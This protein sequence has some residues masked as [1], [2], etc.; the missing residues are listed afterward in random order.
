MDKSEMTSEEQLALWV[1]GNSQ[2][3]GEKRG[4]GQCCP[5]S[6][7]CHPELLAPQEVREIFAGAWKNQN[8]QMTDRMLME[9]LGKAFAQQ[10]ERVYIAGLEA[11]R[12]EID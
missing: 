10:G 3:M 6:S 5:D 11:H 1:S 2:H 8:Y 12:R 9:F 7:C 4:E